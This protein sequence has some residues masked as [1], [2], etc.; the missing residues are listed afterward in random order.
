VTPD[1]TP[2]ADSTAGKMS[3]V[4]VLRGLLQLWRAFAHIMVRDGA[5]LAEATERIERRAPPHHEGG[6][7]R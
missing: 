6:S 4:L 5:R 7:R 3:E 2:E 1:V